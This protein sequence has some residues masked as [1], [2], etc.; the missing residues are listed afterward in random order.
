VSV[1]LRVPPAALLLFAL[2]SGVA[3]GIASR[4]AAVPV[5]VLVL[6]AGARRWQPRLA[7]WPVVALLAWV[8]GAAARRLD[9]AGCPAA[10]PGGVVR[11]GIRVLEPTGGTVP[12]LVQPRAP[13][14]G[15]VLARFRERDTVRA[16]DQL[17]VEARWLPTPGRLGPSSGLLV[18]RNTRR[19]GA[20]PGP[21]D[22]L[23]NWLHQASRRLY[24][25][26]AGIVDALMLGRRG[27]ID[28]TITSAFSRS[29]LVH[30]LSISGFHVGL[31]AGW[32]LLSL[33]AASVG[34]HRAALLAAGVVTLY[35]LFIGA[36][37]PA[38]RAVLLTWLVTLERWRQR[39]PGPA[40]LF[41]ATAALVVVLDPFAVFD[42]GAWLSVTALG[43]ATLASRW[44]DVAMSKH[45]LVRIV[46]GSIG[47]TLGTA[48][49]AAFAL[50]VIAPIGVVVNL[51]AIPVAAVAV[52]GVLGSV[53]ALPVAARHADALAA[54]SGL[55][56]DLMERTAAF[57]A[58]VPGGAYTFEPGP[59]PALVSVAVLIVA[60]WVIGRGNT[61]REAGRRLAWA[62]ALAFAW[63]VAARLTFPTHTGTR[64]TLHFLSVGQG[65][66]ALIR[67]PGNRWILIDAGPVTRD[68]DA[69]RRVV[70]PFLVR[71]GVRR[72]AALV[73]SHAH[74]DHY[75]GAAAVLAEVDVDLVLEPGRLVADAPYRELLEAVERAGVGWRPF[76]AGDRLRIDG[77]EIE[78][79]H[80][81]TTWS[82]WG[83]DLNEDSVVL[84]V[85]SGRFAAVFTG[86]AGFPVEAR[87]GGR[88]GSAELVKVGH[89]GSATATSAAWLDELDPAVAIVST[90]PNRYG[91]PAPETMRRLAAA[92][93]DIW[94]TDRD[95]T[96]SV[97]VDD[98][99]MRV[100]GR[101]GER[102]YP[103]R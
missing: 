100:R 92:G 16:G 57:G 24:G 62:A 50:G 76:R 28:P 67:T 74:L 82:S 87:L 71:Q 36:P 8:H 22:G 17:V 53:L 20:D 58:A 63:P 41:M 27:S 15:P 84:A 91:H 32:V 14:R 6:A 103:V 46:T 98:G 95:G 43:G 25:H 55:L 70:V 59:L 1:R 33:R 90:G 61:A 2:V 51:V 99:I 81:D 96:L 101:R 97:R 23:R 3:A 102:V 80:P 52:P 12:A 75:G 19:V 9:A 38:M 73:L 78:A 54:G 29:G 89:H 86:D 60:G 44:S 49:V 66:A 85:R 10:L 69:G 47:A 48:P 26:R 77:V 35:V 39:H 13:C 4:G 79:L 30:I 88:V 34:R 72:L 93:V 45:G 83:V 18:V 21:L 40:P 5:A 94:R 37:A 68:R 56:L 11:L 31:I 64:L 42:L 7:L 65:D